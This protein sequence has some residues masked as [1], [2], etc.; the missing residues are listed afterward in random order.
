MI[1]MRRKDVFGNI[2]LAAGDV[3]TACRAAHAQM[4]AMHTYCLLLKG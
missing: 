2:D 3:K 4:S 1:N